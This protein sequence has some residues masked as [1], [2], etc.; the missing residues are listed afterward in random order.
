MDN[1]PRQLRSF[2]LRMMTSRNLQTVILM[3]S[4]SGTFNGFAKRLNFRGLSFTHTHFSFHLKLVKN[5]DISASL[6][7]KSNALKQSVHA[8]LHLQRDGTSCEENNNPTDRRATLAMTVCDHQ[9]VVASEMKCPEAICPL[10]PE[11][12]CVRNRTC[13]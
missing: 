10:T 3:W 5:V 4:S 1:W 9:R 13:N 12:H 6:R 11:S 7:T 8:S 2:R